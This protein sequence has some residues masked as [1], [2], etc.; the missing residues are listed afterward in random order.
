MLFLSAAELAVLY[1]FLRPWSY[2]RSWWRPTVAL[3]LFAPWTLFC[4]AASMHAGGVAIL[5]WLWLLVV[6]II[7]LACVAVSAGAAFMFRWAS[8]RASGRPSA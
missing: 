1:L 4:M 3:A 7:L 2:R 6:D 8:H 5:H